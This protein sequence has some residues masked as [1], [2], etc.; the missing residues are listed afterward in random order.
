MTW[1]RWL[2][3]GS[4]LDKKINAAKS[5]VPVSWQTYL[6]C[7]LLRWLVKRHFRPDTNL[8]RYRQ[9][10]ERM[11]T[12]FI[13]VAPDI[14]ATEVYADA[15][16]AR[17]IEVP[18]STTKR[19]ILYLHGGGFC[20]RGPNLYS[21]FLARLCRHTHAKGLLLDYRLTPEHPY[22]AAMQ[23]CLTSYRWL[24][25]QG[26]DPH[27]VIIAGDSAGG[28]LSLVTLTQLRD[29]GEPQPACAVL[30]SPAADMTVSGWSAITKE[31][32]DPFFRLQTLLLL[33][34][35]YLRGTFAGHPSVSP[36]YADFQNLPPLL[37]QAGSTEL[38]LDDSL[39]TAAKAA[40]AGVEVDLQIWRRMPH[41]FQLF[42]WL[43]E[44]HQALKGI[45]QFIKACTANAE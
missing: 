38:L 40:A 6:V 30:L 13:K 27:D 21:N 31:R 22:P 9:R 28:C 12:R 33:K 39:R 45:S 16:P 1:S 7:F 36:V 43:P 29:A 32:E 44:S 19:V 41:V 15:V 17:W 8:T 5:D 10:V 26:H 18:E 37:F 4:S 24:L 42:T 25:N 3:L 11:D 2:A 35:Y 14:C 23:D 20:L 34:H